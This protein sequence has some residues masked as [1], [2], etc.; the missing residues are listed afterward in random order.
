MSSAA[1]V[2]GLTR[3]LQTVTGL[4]IVLPY[5]PREFQDL[6]ALY[7]TLDSLEHKRAGQVTR[8]LYRVN[9]RLVLLRQ[10]NEQ[11]ELELHAF[12]DAILAAVDNDGHL[13]GALTSGYAEIVS[14]DAGYAPESDPVFRVMDFVC[15]VVEK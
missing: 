14:G 8:N 10:D 5:E 11:A 12:S 15:E 7:V 4:T 9:C 13:G 6:P 1:I 3:C 2:A